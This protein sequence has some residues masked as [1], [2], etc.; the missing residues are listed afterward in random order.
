M[1]GRKREDEAS[2]FERAPADNAGSPGGS[3]CPNARSSTEQL[4]TTSGRGSR[5]CLPRP[6]RSP[7]HLF[8]AMPD[9][10][11]RAPSPRSQG[12]SSSRVTSQGAGRSRPSEKDDDTVSPAVSPPFHRPLSRGSQNLPPGGLGGSGLSQGVSSG[13]GRQEG[14]PKG[15]RPA[16][17]GAAACGASS[18]CIGRGGFRR[19]QFAQDHPRV[20]QMFN[21]DAYNLSDIVDVCDDGYEDSGTDAADEAGAPSPGRRGEGGASSQEGRH[22]LEDFAADSGAGR[23]GETGSRPPS[24]PSSLVAVAAALENR[25]TRTPRSA[26]DLRRS[27]AAVGRMEGSVPFRPFS[28]M[29]TESESLGALLREP[30]WHK[31]AGASTHWGGAGKHIFQAAPSGASASNKLKSVHFV[32]EQMQKEKTEV[33]A[34]VRPTAQSD[35]SLKG[36]E[37]IRIFCG[38]WNSEYQ[39]FPQGTM[40]PNISPEALA[41]PS[42]LPAHLPERVVEELLDDEDAWATGDV[43][44]FDQYGKHR[45]DGES[46]RKV[47]KSAWLSTPG[48]HAPSDSRMVERKSL[49]RASTLKLKAVK[50]GEQPLSDWVLP[51]Y[52]VYVITLQET[53]SD[54]IFH[55][56]MTYLCDVNGRPY[57]RMRAAEDKI[58]GLGD[59]AWTQ[60]KSTS[61]AA[62]A[63]ADLLRPKGP[64]EFLSSK[65]IPL[66]FFNGSKGAVSLL[67]RIWDQFVCFLGCHMP[68][69]AT[70]DRIKART[71]ILERLCEL[72]SGVPRTTLD[73]VFHHV[74]WM[75][76]FNFRTR[77]ISAA[78]A[79]E[80]LDSGDLKALFQYDECVGPHGEDL[81]KQGF[82]ESPVTFPPTYKKVD[83]RPPVDFTD[84]HW[85]AKEYQ[86][87][88][89]VKWYKGGRQEDRNPSWTDRVFKWSI[90]EV[91]SLLRLEEENY[92][93]AMPT[94]PNSFLNASDHS[95]VGTGLVMYPLDF[96]YALPSVMNIENPDPSASCVNEDVLQANSSSKDV[97][98]KLSSGENSGF[99]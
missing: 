85:A 43:D 49:L 14:P 24:L 52:D 66:S 75:G 87:K 81:R 34:K 94:R 65:A 25:Q 19:R 79:V 40:T 51:G 57:V 67:M 73:G 76:D 36:V 32:Y 93:A 31:H 63:R 37:P 15:W 48:T 41:A 47:G 1:E 27:T 29:P 7:G 59:G 33:R 74:L 86:T 53:I 21:L 58:S 6:Y 12:S 95:P 54:S 26:G 68:A 91:A 98:A 38:T 64:I 70:E 90:P 2:S 42:V 5:S 69:T 44:A 9:G 82:H 28:A 78:K 88:F 71:W 72:Y 62:W 11:H 96:N 22:A 3:P 61:I 56:I 46:E 4:S 99:V 16:G 39:D 10:T 89:T 77:N 83:G 45:N 30:Q 8:V 13:S 84:A 60:F 97:C 18:A 80:L 20:D 23:D 92:F 50:D 17:G 35:N 55:A